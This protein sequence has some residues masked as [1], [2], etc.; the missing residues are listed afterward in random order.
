[1]INDARK[2]GNNYNLIMYWNKK[3]NTIIFKSI[4]LIVLDTIRIQFFK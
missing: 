4:K 3:I 1:M 2:N